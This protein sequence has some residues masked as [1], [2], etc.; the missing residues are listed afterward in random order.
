M[1]DC[2]NNTAQVSLRLDTERCLR[3]TSRKAR[4]PND[5]IEILRAVSGKHA[6]QEH[7]VGVFLNAQNDVLS[8]QLVSIGGLDRASVDPRALFAGA[9]L[10]GASAFVVGHNHPSGSVQPSA[11]DDTLTSELIQG[12]RLLGIKLLDHIVF[13]D[14]DSFSY[15]QNGRLS[16]T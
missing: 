4:T 13:S 8:A 16:F 5:V 6:A 12:G 3:G 15:V 10:S 2:K 11:A 9:M 14:V 7:F 1:K